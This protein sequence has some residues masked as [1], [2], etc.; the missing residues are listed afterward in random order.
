MAPKESLAII[1]GATSGISQ[2]L[3]AKG[4]KAVIADVNP[5]TIESFDTANERVLSQKTDVQSSL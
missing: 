3:L 2:H 4:W 5:P 1:T